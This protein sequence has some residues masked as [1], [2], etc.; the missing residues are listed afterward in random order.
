M[1]KDDIEK[2]FSSLEDFSKIPPDDL[3]KGIEEKLDTSKKKKDCAVKSKSKFV[4]T[5]HA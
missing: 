5:F 3:W 2:I 4:A 1:K